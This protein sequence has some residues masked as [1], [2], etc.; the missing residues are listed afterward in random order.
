M[1]LQVGNIVVL[2]DNDNVPADIIVLSTSHEESICYIET[3]NLDGETNLKIKLA[4]TDTSAIFDSKNLDT[5]IKMLHKL[6]EAVLN[7]EHPNNRLYVYE[8]SLK[9]KGHPR[10]SPIDNNNLLLRGSTVRNINWILGCVVFTGGD[11]KLMMNSKHP[12]HKRSNV[13]RR[14][15]KYLI[16]VFSLLFV[17]ILVSTLVSVIYIYEEPTI[18]H[19]FSGSSKI[20]SA[21]NF[22]TFLILYNSLVPISLY[23]TMDVVRVM[24]AKFIQ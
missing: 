16:I 20:N 2:G 5:T 19:Y 11:T 15:N 12:P 24:Q 10:A 22:I 13:E 9:I 3:S 7:S 8:G 4:L 17:M 18:Y 23:V 14:V 1:N 21:L 6:D